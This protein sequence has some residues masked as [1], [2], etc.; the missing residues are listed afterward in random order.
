M[1]R[2]TA[3]P[4]RPPRDGIQDRLEREALEA[5]TLGAID[6]LRPLVR[7]N[8]HKL[9]A[10]L[11]KPDMQAVAAGAI[12]GWL[13]ARTA[14]IGFGDADA[15]ERFLLEPSAAPASRSEQIVVRQP[16]PHKPVTTAPGDIFPPSVDLSGSAAA[17]DFEPTL[18]ALL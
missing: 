13:K 2:R 6:A 7:E 10:N 16:V 5:A 9:V 15:L 14:Q 17:D 4:A 1:N 8:K 11:A 3:E 18:E 12:A